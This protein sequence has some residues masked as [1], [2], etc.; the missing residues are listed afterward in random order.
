MN[1]KRNIVSFVLLL[2][3]AFLASA[4]SMAQCAMCKAVAENAQGE[5]GY[6]LANGLNSGIIYLMGI[7]Y[8]LLATLAIVFFRKQIGGFWR[9]FNQIH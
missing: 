9:S 4:D 3:F 1:R 5:S 7:P 6:G 8:L 2:T